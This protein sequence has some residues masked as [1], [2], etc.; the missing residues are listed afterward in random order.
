[1]QKLNEDHANK[2]KKGIKVAV[3][4]PAESAAVQMWMFEKG[5]RWTWSSAEVNHTEQPYL[6]GCEDGTIAFSDDDR[7]FFDASSEK[8]V[9]FDFKVFATLQEPALTVELN[10]ETMHPDEAI[11]LIKKLK[12][13]NEK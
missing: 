12:E 7:S 8:E 5:Y 3:S 1:M 4:N 9:F 13:E 10:G 6:Y 11:A 2:F